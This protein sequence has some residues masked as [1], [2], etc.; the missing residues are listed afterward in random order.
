MQLRVSAHAIE[1][2]VRTKFVF[3]TGKSTRD[4]SKFKYLGGYYHS[5]IDL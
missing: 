5:D 1:F 3:S 2:S 4:L